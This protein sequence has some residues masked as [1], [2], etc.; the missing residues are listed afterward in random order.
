M[1]F[2]LYYQSIYHSFLPVTSPYVIQLSELCQT[3]VDKEGADA[4]ADRTFVA[5]RINVF[6]LLEDT[7]FHLK[8]AVRI[9]S[10]GHPFA[11]V[12]V[13]GKNLYIFGGKIA[14]ER[15]RR[16]LTNEA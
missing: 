10:G 9:T 12:K 16:A 8:D 4:E 2:R 15:L 14:D 5:T 6:G 11:S 1:I 13:D 7:K 3:G